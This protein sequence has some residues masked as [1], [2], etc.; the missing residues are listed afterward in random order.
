MALRQRPPIFVGRSK[1]YMDSEELMERGLEALERADFETAAGA[2]EELVVEEAGHAEGWF[3]LGVCYYEMGRIEDAAESFRRAV[4]ADPNN[5][6]AHY[7]LGN[8]SGVK[9]ELEE[10]VECYR[11]ALAIDPTH[12]K[13]SEFLTRTLSLIESR[14]HFRRALHLINRGEHGRALG[15]LVRSIAAFPSSPARDQL[16]RSVDEVAARLAAQGWNPEVAPQ[17][18]Y[19]AELCRK[20][21]AAL[22]RK[23]W[24]EVEAACRESLLYRDDHPF[25]FSLLGIAL[26]K[27]KRLEDAARAWLHALEIDPEYDFSKFE[28]RAGS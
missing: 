27:L 17:P 7:M 21:L 4:A 2:F 25:V 15:E 13:A 14:E 10:A 28:A 11:R 20:A 18:P 23:S 6:N 8:V 12:A 9:G 5:S 3:Y 16:E 19:W 1:L 22:K 24:P 26:Y